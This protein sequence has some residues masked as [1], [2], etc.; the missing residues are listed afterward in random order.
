[1]TSRCILILSNHRTGSSA[2]AGALERLGVPMGGPGDVCPNG[3][4]RGHY[5]DL[6]ILRL[7]QQMCGEFRSGHAWCSPDEWDTWR[8]PQP[9]PAP[10]IDEYRAVLRQRAATRA[11]WGY[12]DPRLCF[13]APLFIECCPADVR[14]LVARRDPAACAQ[15]LWRRDAPADRRFTL[16]KANQVIAH[17]DRALEQVLQDYPSRTLAEVRYEELIAQPRQILG[18]LMRHIQIELV[19]AAAAFIDEDLQHC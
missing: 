7:H 1:M 17:Y 2:L 10:W 11:V 14:F 13:L 19:E 9:D 5:E 16:E 12:K 8:F 6:A 15:S 4:P 3:N 18:D